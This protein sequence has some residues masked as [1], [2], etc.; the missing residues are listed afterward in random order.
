MN[1]KELHDLY[2]PLWDRVP[3]TRPKFGHRFFTYLAWSMPVDGGDDFYHEGFVWKYGNEKPRLADCRN[4]VEVAALCR[5]AVEDWLTRDVVNYSLEISKYLGRPPELRWRVYAFAGNGLD[6]A[7][8][9]GPTIHH[10]LVAAALAVADAGKG[11][12]G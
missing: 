1:A 4:D 7:S 12:G 2:G 9:S 10:A 5:V 6:V 8:G 3:E 11:G